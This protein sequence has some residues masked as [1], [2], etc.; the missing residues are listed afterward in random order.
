MHRT[1]AQVLGGD[2]L[3]GRRL[4]Q[5]RTREEDGA[6]I[7]HDH[8]LVA[9]RRDVGPAGGRRPEDRGDLRDA[10]GAH[11]RLIEED[12]SE[13]IPVGEH[14]VLLEQHRAARVDEVDAREPVGRRDLLRTQMLLDRDRV[15]RAAGDRGV[16][17]DD[18]AL[19]TRDAPHAGDDPGGGHLAAV[20]PEG[21][22]RG[23]LDERRPDVEQ[24]V[25]PVP[26]EQLSASDVAITSLRAAAGGHLSQAFVE[27]VEIA[28]VCGPE[29]VERAGHRR[30]F[31]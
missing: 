12:P 26:R 4:H 11:G 29:A 13:V 1:T 15:V 5:R 18:H 21:R 24:P 6:L 31:S 3:P 30:P 14:L 27:Q 17:G 8:R 22:E 7:A 25:D 16:V 10:G 28:L 23:H 2:I 20:H 9:H 19:A